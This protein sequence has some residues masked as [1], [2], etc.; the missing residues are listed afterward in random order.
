MSII[1]YEDITIHGIKDVMLTVGVVFSIV[2]RVEAYANELIVNL[3][4]SSNTD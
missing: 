2:L 1:S 4:R 3:L